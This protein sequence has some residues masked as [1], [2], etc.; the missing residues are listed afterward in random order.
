MQIF[1]YV[2]ITHKAGEEKEMGK[3]N[4]A[5]LRCSICSFVNAFFGSKSICGFRGACLMWMCSLYRRSIILRMHRK[6]NPVC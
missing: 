5:K 6:V 4:S 3:V 2:N 1:R